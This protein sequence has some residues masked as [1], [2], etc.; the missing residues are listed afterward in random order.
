MLCDTETLFTQSHSSRTFQNNT[1]LL[2][3]KIFL[4]NSIET[5]FK[6][7]AVDDFFALDILEIELKLR[8][9]NSAKK[10]NT[11]NHFTPL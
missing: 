3:E 5:V 2:V 8:A 11:I 10:C 4:P 7:L 1:L 6:K 9:F